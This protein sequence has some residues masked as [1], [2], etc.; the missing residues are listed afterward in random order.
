MIRTTIATSLRRLFTTG[1]HGMPRLVIDRPGLI[2]QLPIAASARR[3]VPVAYVPGLVSRRPANG[4]RCGRASEAV[5][6]GGQAGTGL[7]ADH[8][9]AVVADGI[10]L[11][12]GAARERSDLRREQLG[13]FLLSAA[14][15]AG[16]TLYRRIAVFAMTMIAGHVAAWGQRE[17]RWQVPQRRSFRET[18]VL[19]PGRETH[20][21]TSKP[22]RCTRAAMW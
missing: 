17:G 18:L 7:D 11:P 12:D 6:A 2:T 10:E 19:T 1:Q 13:E 3:A 20:F 9:S 15:I 22:R 4:E 8:D 14:L 16:S 21:V 5:P